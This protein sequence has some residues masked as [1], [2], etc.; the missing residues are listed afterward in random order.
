MVLSYPYKIFLHIVLH[1]QNFDCEFPSNYEVCQNP[2][3]TIS[4][5]DILDTLG[6]NEHDLTFDFIIL[7]SAFLILPRLIGYYYLNQNL[8]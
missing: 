3:D 7:I 2:G 1:E 6:F 5:E 4:G 8:K